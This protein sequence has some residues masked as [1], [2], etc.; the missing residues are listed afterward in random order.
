[1]A[2]RQTYREGPPTPDEYD[3]IFD[4]DPAEQAPYY[5]KRYE[6]HL[7]QTEQEKA[8]EIFRLLRALSEHLDAQDRKWA[9]RHR[10]RPRD[11]ND[12]TGQQDVLTSPFPPAGADQSE[13]VHTNTK[14]HSS[15][16]RR[17]AKTK[18]SRSK[19][20]PPVPDTT[21]SESSDGLHSPNALTHRDTHLQFTPP[22]K[23]HDR[24]LT[25][26]IEGSGV[27]QAAAPNQKKPANTH[28]IEA[29]RH[30]AQVINVDPGGVVTTTQVAVSVRSPRPPRAGNP[31]PDE[32]R[33]HYEHTWRD[34]DISANRRSSTP[35]DLSASS[36]EGSYETCPHWQPIDTNTPSPRIKPT[37]DHIAGKPL[38]TPDWRGP[39]TGRDTRLVP[40]RGKSFKQS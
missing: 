1:M 3:A 14:E 2:H 12:E 7:Y 24:G 8:Q 34:F 31:I 19:A 10:P 9:H 18:K 15:S 38:S 37:M 29:P 6:S 21:A 17:P 20:N 11:A 5:N 40:D 23:S 28:Q 22:R 36:S 39:I 4:S 33:E 13:H 25:T 27:N 35:L 16:E 26:L 32:N 30:V